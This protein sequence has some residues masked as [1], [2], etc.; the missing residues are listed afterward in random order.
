MTPAQTSPAPEAPYAL[1]TADA[2]LKR[3][4]RKVGA[5]FS[6]MNSVVHA[7]EGAPEPLLKF[8][9]DHKVA[10]LSEEEGGDP[11]Q[12]F[13]IG[14]LHGDFFALHSMLRSAME[15][16]PDCRIL[17]LG[18]IVDRGEFP[19]ETM[20]LLLEWG[21]HHPKRL[22]WIAGNHDVAFYRAPSGDFVS[23]VSPAEFL[24]TLNA[25]DEMQS[26]RH[27]LG[28]L[29]VKLTQGLPRA[30]LFPDGLL[31]THGGFPLADRHEAGA[32]AADEAAYLS[33]LNSKECLEDF[34]W[35]RIHRAPKKM[36][37]RHS[38][39]SQYGFK[40]FEAFCA[41]KPEF[42]P[43]SRMIT[44]HEHPAGGH[45]VHASY[46]I[47]PAMTLVGL[48]FDETKSGTAERYRHYRDTLALAQ[49]RR[50]AL[51]ELVPVAVNRD[52][53]QMMLPNIDISRPAPPSE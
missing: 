15:R 37:D 25:E 5:L 9:H 40:D 8:G 53:L 34:T 4:R 41:L 42:F 33:W 29:F 31:A 50:G 48:G 28:A 43:V 6:R 26:F 19:I 45:A 2:D 7:K 10:R 32:S 23:Q 13:F 17:F 52:E 12:W 38:R 20:F 35:T 36:P 22:A 30:L 47:N 46:E 44:G 21:L 18:D 3:I 16:R 39:G 49:G 24:Q 27:A 1:T 51:P 14:D 11:E